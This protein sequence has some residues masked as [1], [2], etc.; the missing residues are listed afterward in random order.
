[1]TVVAAEAV[2]EVHQQHQGFAPSREVRTTLDNRLPGQELAL[3][4]ETQPTGMAEASAAGAR[5]RDGDRCGGGKQLHTASA[6]RRSEA[7]GVGACVEEEGDGAV[8]GYIG[9]DGNARGLSGRTAWG[10][11]VGGGGG[12][13]TRREGARA[14][15]GRCGGEHSRP[16]AHGAQRRPEQHVSALAESKAAAQRAPPRGLGVR[17]GAAASARRRSEACGV[18]RLWRGGGAV[19]EWR[20]DRRAQRGLLGKGRPAPRPRGKQLFKS[21]RA[22]HQQRQGFA[23]SRP[24]GAA[25]GR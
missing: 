15:R 9:R 10:H 2:R 3:P 21:V 7:C 11:G 16:V 4:R 12:P 20:R 1:M 18:G 17:V 13:P 19:V 14:G 6:R 23:L 22:V 25:R 8:G 24:G 5:L